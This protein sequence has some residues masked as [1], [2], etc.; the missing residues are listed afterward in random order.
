M[1][2]AVPRSE[3][4]A[5]SL[6]ICYHFHEARTLKIPPAGSSFILDTHS[7]VLIIE[8]GVFH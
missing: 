8:A 4:Q 1:H 7:R 3:T 2:G 6:G 5:K